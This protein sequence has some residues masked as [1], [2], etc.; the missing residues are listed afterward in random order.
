MVLEFA[1]A[2]QGRGSSRPGKSTGSQNREHTW[3]QG[4]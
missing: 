2:M 3:E 4:W 1:V